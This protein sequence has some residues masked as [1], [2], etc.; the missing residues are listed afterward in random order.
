MIDPRLFEL[1]RALAFERLLTSLSAA[2]VQAPA[3]LI[4]GHVIDAL[5]SVGESLDLDRAQIGQ[6]ASGGL[7]VT[8]QWTRDEAWRVPP[9]LPAAAV[10]SVTA[11]L[12]RG[13]ATIASRMTDIPFDADREFIA[14]F[15]TRSVA[16]LPMTVDGRFVGAATFGAIREE[17]HWTPDVIG[18]LQLIVDIIGS[19]LARKAADLELSAALVENEQ[20]RRRL[21]RENTYLQ[22]ELEAVQDFGEI[23]GRSSALRAVLHKVDQ[24]AATDAPVLLLGETGTGKE[25]MARAIHLRSGRSSR[26]LI[27]VNC[28]ALPTSLIESELFGHEKGAFTGAAEARAGRF[29]IADGSTL[30]LDE[31][32][33]LDPA[34]QVKLLRALQEGE[35][36]RLGSSVARKVNVRI[37]AATNRNLDQAMDDRRF[38]EDLYYRLSVFPIEVPPLRDRRDDIPL[39]IWHFIQSRQRALGRRIQ[40][41]PGSTMETMLS[42]DWPGNVR[43][44]QN[45]VERALILSTG[46]VLALEEA[47]GRPAV[48]RSGTERVH[49]PAV[50]EQ[51]AVESLADAER[52]HIVSVLRQCMWRIEG[53][54]QAAAR[55]ELRPSTLRNRMRKLGIRRPTSG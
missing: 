2:F 51:R 40:S 12:S 10:P 3:A 7:E 54:G 45:M 1:E 34:L 42:Y 4:D 53:A 23:V 18:R 44:L 9:F 26:P 47:F 21:E 38:R 11:R 55:L 15:G 46:S 5:K 49:P 41:V 37:I 27:A 36:T 14:K 52:A 48:G 32:G 28:A 8:H 29:E 50:N 39:L 25:L 13:E 35:I 30:F 16:V 43:E 20:L 6:T 31:I 33:D 22:E 19:A 17:R 24:V